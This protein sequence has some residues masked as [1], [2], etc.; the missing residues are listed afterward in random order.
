R[1]TGTFNSG[2]G[3][4]RC[5]G[6]REGKPCREGALPQDLHTL[7]R[8]GADASSDQRLVRHRDGRI[9][10]TRVHSR[11]DAAEV[12]FIIVDRERV[13]EATLRQP[14]VQRHLPALEALDRDAGPGFLPLYAASAS[15]AF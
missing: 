4:L 6:H 13:M 11:L 10:L 7:A 1:S 3:A 15:L 5:R 14:P 8:F 9:K 2:H 12:N